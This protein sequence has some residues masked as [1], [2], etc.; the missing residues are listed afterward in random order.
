MKHALAALLVGGFGLI[1]CT[2][3]RP[4]SAAIVG[5]PFPIPTLDISEKDGGEKV[6]V[7]A[8]GCFW[9][10][11]GVFERIDGVKDVV[12][13]YSGGSA[14]DASYQIVGMGTSGHAE[15][16]RIT[17]D[18]SKVSYGTLLRVFFQIAHDPT[19]LNYQGPDHGPQ[20]RS[21]IFYAD[22]GQKETASAYIEQLGAAKLFSESIVTQL[23]PLE[24][25]YPAEAYHQNFMALNPD[26]PYIVRFD[27]PKVEEL[28]R[29]YPDLLKNP[30]KV[31]TRDWR[32]LPVVDSEVELKYPIVK[33][34]EEWK[35]ELGSLAYQVLRHE[36][37]ER[38]FTGELLEE[39]RPGTFYSAATG[40]PLFRSEAKFDS[41]TGWP[42]FSKP[43]D[44]EAVVL[45]GDR[46]LGMERVA[47][48]DSSSGSHLGHVFDD[49]PPVSADF[50]EG[51]GLRYCMNS[52]S[53]L[54]VADGETPP[55]IV[56]QY[57]EKQKK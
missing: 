9:G 32:G 46:S 54:F 11:E 5:T 49:G 33:S 56:K 52:V 38:A 14:E 42:S 22:E 55:E 37:T 36:G 34:D 53:L 50:E 23:L 10:V 27:Q 45:L 41:G 3:A 25:F 17:Y 12:S 35:K 48:V 13:G 4:A 40:Q 2:S 6:A 20:Y 7:F 18:P 8:G 28:E 47:V 57:A 39:H 44:Q 51:T 24:A 21:A 16:V 30:P 1:S 26:Y 19:Q 31:K 43:I 29:V 15:S